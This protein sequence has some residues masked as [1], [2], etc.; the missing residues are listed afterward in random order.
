MQTPRRR[1]GRADVE[2]IRSSTVDFLRARRS[3]NGDFLRARAH[4]RR[5]WCVPPESTFDLSDDVFRSLSLIPTVRGIPDRCRPARHRRPAST[6]T[7]AASLVCGWCPINLLFTVLYGDSRRYRGDFPGFV[8]ESADLAL[9]QAQTRSRTYPRVCD[10]VMT[11]SRY[12]FA[13]T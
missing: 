2:D 1:L 12:A 3:S 10:C 8:A 5:T 11:A 4:Q 7:S 13:A 6:H 9:Q